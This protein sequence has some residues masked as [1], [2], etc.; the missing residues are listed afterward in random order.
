MEAAVGQYMNVMTAKNSLGY[1]VIGQPQ[2]LNTMAAA[3]KSFSGGAKL[4]DL[5]SVPVTKDELAL[6]VL[7]ISLD[8]IGIIEPTPFADGTNA[9]IS[10]G[11]GDGLGAFLSAVGIVP[12]LGDLAKAGK[13]GKWAATIEKAID[14]AKTDPA[15]LAKIRPALDKLNYALGKMGDA[16]PDAL[17]GMKTKLDDLLRAGDRVFTDGVKAAAERLGIPPEKVQDIL[18]IAKP[19]KPGDP[20]RP[21]PSTYMS[22]EQIASHLAKFDDGAIRFTS[23]SQVAKRGTLGPSGGFVMPATEFSELMKSAKGDLKIVENALGLDA[24]TLSSSDTLIAYIERKDLQGL[25]VPSGNESGV[26]E[27]LWL[28]GGYTSGG[29]PEAV[30]DFPKDVVYQEIKL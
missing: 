27:T 25:R 14:L 11:R 18:D 15:F 6:D 12:Y 22:K 5:S 13:L 7:Q 17:K 2:T 4:P 30:V 23:R 1:T 26:H 24:G 16:M 3:I 29:I 21:D 8:V 19:K 10:L 20:M 28:P 9:L